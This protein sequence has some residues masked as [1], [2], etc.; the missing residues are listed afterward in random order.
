MKTIAFFNNK[1]GVGK[2]SLVYHL[3]W[4]YA[5]LGLNVIAADLDPQAN[6]T[7]MFLEDERL[8][9]VWSDNGHEQT[10][11]G[12]FRP[13]LD[14]TG[15]VAAPHVEDISPGLGLV[16][17]DLALG[18]A[19]DELSGQWPDCLDRKPRAFRVLS[20]LWRILMA[21]GKSVEADLVL[22]DVG[23]N[24]GALNRAALV[25]AQD[26]VIPLAPDLYSMQGL[27]NLGPTLRRWRA[28]WE[29]RLERRPGSIVDLA[30]P[31]G[32]MHPAGYVVLQPAVRL[33]RPVKA[34]GRWMGR[35]PDEYRLSVLGE[36]G[37]LQV[38]TKPDPN[39]LATLKHYRSLMPLAQEARKPIFSLKPADGA[40][41]GHTAAVRDCY[42][43]FRKLASHIAARSGLAMP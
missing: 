34:Y 43:D 15:D 10:V 33:D 42:N 4:M 12:A 14:G 13:L 6:L 2:T 24:L 31:G 35:I 1:G 25:A 28:E 21:A 11:Y 5:D 32:E 9:E 38:T 7:S 27:R 18:N 40:F 3:S 37:S 36:S 20:G 39:S 8:E 29:E 41:G 26:V 17:G 22:I 30:L 23:P 19:E 16:V